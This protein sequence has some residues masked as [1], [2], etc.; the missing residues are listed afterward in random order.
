MGPFPSLKGNK[1]IIVAVDYLSKWVEE[2]ELPTNDARVIVKFLQS[3]FSRFGTPRAIISDRGT[4]FCNEQFARVMTKYGVTH[5]LATAYHPQ[6]SGQ[7][8]VSNQGLKHIL[9]RTVRENRT[10]RSDKFDDAIWAFRT[11]FKTPIGCTPYKL[12]YG[13]SCH[14]PIELEHKAYWALKHVNFDLKTAERTKK[15]HDSK[16]KNLIFNVSDQVLLFNSRLKIFSGKL[17]T[18]WSSPFTITQAFPYGIV[19]LSQPDGT[20]FKV[21]GHRVKHYFRG[22]DLAKIIKKWLKPDK[23]EHEIVKNAQ[24]PDPKTFLKKQSHWP[25]RVSKDQRITSSQNNYTKYIKKEAQQGLFMDCHPGHPYDLKS[26]P[27]AQ[28]LVNRRIQKQ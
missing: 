4:H 1:Y 28:S 10:S 15:L 7:V 16:I 22:T 27:T 19:E 23:I 14:L 25:K 12:I 11:A 3:L 20:N 26:D 6:T 2:K 8:E 18:R 13:K 17:K 5:R 9:K 24:K 21:N